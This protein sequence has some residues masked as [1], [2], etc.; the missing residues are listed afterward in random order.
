[1]CH[2]WPRRVYH[3]LLNESSYPLCPVKDMG[4]SPGVLRKLKG[5]GLRTSRQVVDAF[6]SDLGRRPGCGKATVPA[7]AAWINSHR[8]RS[9]DRARKPKGPEASGSLPPGEG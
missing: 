8:N 3:A 5:S 4:F 9:Q 2:F 1:M 7:V 6:H